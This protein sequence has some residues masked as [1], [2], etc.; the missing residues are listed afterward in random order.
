MVHSVSSTVREH[1]QGHLG[2]VYSWM[3][4]GF[5]A[6]SE[7]ARAALA[8]A[9]APA[10][11]GRLAVDLGCGP[12]FHALPLASLGYRVAAVDPCRPLL[13][14][15]LAH[16]AGTG[17]QVIEAD[18]LDFRRHVAEPAA[19]IVCLGDTL[20]HLPSREAVAALVGEIHG[21]LAPDGLVVL[22][23]RDYS[24][25]ILEGAAR[26]IPVRSDADR[27]LTCFLEYGPEHVTVHDLLHTRA[28]EA[29]RLTVSA[30]PKLRLSPSWVVGLLEQAGLRVMGTSEARGM[31]TLVAGR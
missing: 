11:R 26:F 29:W 10:G 18:L 23:F 4:G 6:A 28:G 2:P 5:A 12:G 17:I 9:G 20:T 7:R 13:D 1:Y 25:S 31:V 22:S 30:Y 24:K 21:G 16:A 19:L 8:E 3:A 14:E 27:I 15:L